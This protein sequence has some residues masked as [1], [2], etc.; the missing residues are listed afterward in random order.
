MKDVDSGASSGVT[1]WQQL[2]LWHRV[3]TSGFSRFLCIREE[4]VSVISMMECKNVACICARSAAAVRSL[5]SCHPQLLQWGLDAALHAPFCHFE[6]V[7]PSLAPSRRLSLRHRGSRRWWVSQIELKCL[8]PQLS[9]MQIASSTAS[10]LFCLTPFSSFF[11]TM[12]LSLDLPLH[13]LM[14]QTAIFNLPHFFLSLL[15][16]YRHSYKASYSIYNIH[17]RWVFPFSSSAVRKP[18]VA[19]TKVPPPT[20]I[21]GLFGPGI[22]I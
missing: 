15:Q 9:S 2:L 8:V 10:N 13:S 21:R 11:T 19:E 6:R 16:V 22:T 12:P 14:F 5:L 1:K 4:Y 7:P 18:V 17:T 3:T 20:E